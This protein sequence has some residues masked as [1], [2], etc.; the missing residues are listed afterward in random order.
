MIIHRLVWQRI[1][2]YFKSDNYPSRIRNENLKVV[3]TTKL[4]T[5]KVLNLCVSIIMSVVSVLLWITTP[6]SVLE[7]PCE[8][9]KEYNMDKMYTISQWLQRHITSIDRLIIVLGL[10]LVVVS[11]D[12]IY[13]AIKYTDTKFSPWVEKEKYGILSTTDKTTEKG[14]NE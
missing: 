3:N 14:K 6:L 8:I 13:D 9:F 4:K 1:V 10:L 11:M 5:N 7:S 12:T 2:E